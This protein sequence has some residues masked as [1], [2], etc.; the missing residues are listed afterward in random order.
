M[1]SW[2]AY[3]GPELTINPKISYILP[4]FYTSLEFKISV[5]FREVYGTHAQL[6]INA[7]ACRR[8]RRMSVMSSGDRSSSSSQRYTHC[9][10]IINR[11]PCIY[12]INRD[13]CIYNINQGKYLLSLH[14][15][16]AL[17]RQKLTSVVCVF[18]SSFEVAKRISVICAKLWPLQD[19]ILKMPWGR[20]IP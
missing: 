8:V 3:K 2:R 4:R 19:N 14:L 1:K 10:Y 17:R 16:L 18:Y 7:K 9:R 12:I 5:H 11:D 15:I 6:R 20:M 13:A